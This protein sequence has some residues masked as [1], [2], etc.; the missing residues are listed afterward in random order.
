MTDQLKEIEFLGYFGDM[1]SPVKSYKEGYRVTLDLLGDQVGQGLLLMALHAHAKR[2]E[3]TE[4]GG[5]LRVKIELL[6]PNG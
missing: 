1:V 5:Q 3:G 6:P 4:I 2:L